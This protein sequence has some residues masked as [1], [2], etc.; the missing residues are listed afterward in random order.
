MIVG[1]IGCGF[2][3]NTLA[4]F[5]EGT[6]EISELYLYDHTISSTEG[7]ASALTKAVSASTVDDL[8]EKVDLVIEAG[9]QEAV[10]EYAK[11]VL[12]RG[13]DLMIMSIGALSDDALWNDLQTVAKKNK[14]R[15]YLPSGAIC[16]IDGLKSASMAGI[17]EI[18]V[19][20]TKPP[21]GLEKVRY[22]TKQ[23]IDLN[24]L[25]QPL[26]IFDGPARDAVKHFPKNIN[27]A[28][29]VSL[30]GIGFDKTRVRLI[31]DPAATRNQHK[32][33]CH[34]RF[35]EFTCEVRNMPS[36]SNPKTSYLAALSAIATLKKIVGG[37]WIGT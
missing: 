14:C 24:N 20:T 37:V 35:G 1:I 16:G 18:I 32:I 12:A 26:V 30:A 28:A 6:D 3:G 4:N 36:M 13:K 23:G 2:I 11:K 29:C 21:K 22:I 31:A 9:S 7:L 25:K 17:D 34:G 8:I 5:I 10:R 19:E 33:K 27:I 15:I